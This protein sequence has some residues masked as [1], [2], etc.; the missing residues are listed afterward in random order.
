MGVLPVVSN[1]GCKT[2]VR[3]WLFDVLRLAYLTVR[4]ALIV[5]T[6]ATRLLVILNVI[7][8]LLLYQVLTVPAVTVNVLF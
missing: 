4:T 6:V 8:A 3:V 1:N 7:V 2:Y 5:G